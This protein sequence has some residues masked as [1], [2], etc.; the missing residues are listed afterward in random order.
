MQYHLIIPSS[1]E[2]FEDYYRLRYTILRKPWAQPEGSEKDSEEDQAFH[3][4]VK[5]NHGRIKGVCRLQKID[6]V[7]GQI[8][9]MAVATEVQGKGLGRM[10]LQAAEERAVQEG[11]TVIILQAREQAVPFYRSNGYII[12]EKTF[13]LFGAVQHYLMQ[14]NLRS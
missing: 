3:F 13:L 11:L 9:Y 12:V 5:D 4:A 14:K 1:A 10:L 2:D 6:Q 8:R 7:T